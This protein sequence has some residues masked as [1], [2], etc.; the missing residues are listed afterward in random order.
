MTGCRMALTPVAPDEAVGAGTVSYLSDGVVAVIGAGGAPLAARLAPQRAVILI[1]PGARVAEG[2]AGGVAADVTAGVTAHPGRAT[3]VSGWL[4]V[5]RIAVE[6]AGEVRADV[7]IDLS[8]APLIDRAVLPPGYFAPVGAA[9]TDAA[10]ETARGLVGAFRKP[11]Y[12]TYTPEI[13]AHERQGQTGCARCLDVCGAEA[14]RSEGTVIHVEPWLCQGCA[15]CALACPTGA[16]SVTAPDRAA[17]LDATHAALAQE[18]GA[19]AVSANGGDGALA[20]PAL[21]TFGEE[22][23]LAALAAGAQSVTLDPEPDAPPQTQA[24][25]AGRLAMA[26]AMT[27]ALGLGAGTVRMAGA[28]AYPASAARDAAPITPPPTARKRDFLNAALARLEP[29]GGFEPAPLP[30][31]APVGAIEIDPSACTLCS[32]CARSCPTAAIRYAED[33]TARIE[34]VEANCVQC[35]LCARMCPEQAITLAPRLAPAAVRAG[36]RSLNAAPLAACDACGTAFMPQP[37]RDAMLRKATAGGAD[38]P[39]LAQMRK[40]PECRHLGTGQRL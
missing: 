3:A 32:V 23:W 18:G 39:M 22:L 8:A 7:V 10:V 14:I 40:C 30:Q 34:F 16:L 33:D 9:A 5:F 36:W 28:D 37:L 38:A 1:A 12:F 20:V 13:C 29:E 4:G 6:G 24:L 17:L 27:A 35:G 25:L 19:L 21:A 26:Q 31:G 2:A 11:K 15:A